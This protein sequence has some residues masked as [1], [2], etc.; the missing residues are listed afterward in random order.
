V[1]HAEGVGSVTKQAVGSGGGTARNWAA[2]AILLLAMAVIGPALNSGKNLRLISD[3]AALL[4][5]PALCL[6]T[7]PRLKTA[8]ARASFLLFAPAM[9]AVILEAV[10]MLP[11]D[12]DRPRLMLA[13]VE[14]VYIALAAVGLRQL[15][16]ETGTGAAGFKLRAMLVGGAIAQLMMGGRLTWFAALFAL[17]VVLILLVPAITS[18]S[19]IKYRK[20]GATGPELEQNS[21]ALLAAAK[22]QRLFRNPELTLTDLASAAGVPLAQASQAL[23][24]AGGT[25]FPELIAQ[26][27]AEEA[28]RLLALPDNANVSVEPIGMEAGFRSR[29]NFYAAFRRAYG[30]TPVE[31]R[32]AVLQ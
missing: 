31:Y 8:A 26:L 13:A 25:S 5:G 9:S 29:S 10:F 17:A 22:D 3:A 19:A 28:A 16:R 30:V 18:R 14:T 20:S 23:S 32:A 7:I 21:A 27:R 6:L 1:S 11:L 12:F 2:V 15:A 4:L 24:Q